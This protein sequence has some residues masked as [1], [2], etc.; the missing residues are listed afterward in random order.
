MNFIKVHKTIMKKYLSLFIVS[1]LFTSFVYA[2]SNFSDIKNHWARNHILQ[3][4][5]LGFMKGY[6]DGTF[7][8]K[9][10]VSR[11]ELAVIA[12]R[13]AGDPN[14]QFTENVSD[15]SG[16][17]SENGIKKA[18]ELGLMTTENGKF[19]PS[20]LATRQDVAF[21]V[22]KIIELK[23]IPVPS[24]NV[25]PGDISSSPYQSQIL[26]AVAS[27]SMAG[28]PNGT[29]APLKNITRAELAGIVV[30][31]SDFLKT[32]ASAPSDSNPRPPASNNDSNNNNNGSGL[33]IN[34]NNS[35]KN[36]Q[37]TN[38]SSGKNEKPLPEI[39]NYPDSGYSPK[40]G[41]QAVT[42]ETSGGGTKVVEGEYNYD[43]AV[44]VLHL[45]NQ[46]R[47]KAGLH[48]LSWAFEIQDTTDLRAAEITNYFEHTRPNGKE[49]HDFPG[50]YITS[51]V[52][53]P[54]DVPPGASITSVGENIAGGQRTPE[55]VVINWMT[56]PGHR[57]NILRKDFKKLSVSCFIEN[58]SSTYKYYWVQHFLFS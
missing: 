26:S 7:G 28:Y 12:S 3:S 4:Y 51:Y 43:Y 14:I 31:S 52:D 23:K 38:Q 33:S 2:E 6:S 27:N 53:S 8:V 5:E 47:Q 58:G 41:K 48:P 36:S 24:S 37:S 45:V 19:Q 39:A 49:W 16:R 57:E 32:G 9:K 46:E 54:H 11:E 29:F 13:L 22:A 20:K 50:S 30:R 40:P 10:N 34:N 42:I 21:A 18:V 1:L 44:R 15:I 56:S 17:W 25:K 55:E 35:G